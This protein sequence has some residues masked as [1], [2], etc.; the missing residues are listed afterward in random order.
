[1]PAD[2]NG[3]SKGFAAVSQ[4][5]AAVAGSFGGLLSPDCPDDA[6]A[7]HNGRR[8]RPAAD[9]FFSRKP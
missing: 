8:E 2:Q 1:M 4:E 6:R 7:S 5:F 3:S 9:P